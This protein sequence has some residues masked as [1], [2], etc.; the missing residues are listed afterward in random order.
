MHLQYPF[1]TV[2]PN[3][4]VWIP[5]ESDYRGQGT[6]ADNNNERRQLDGAGGEGLALC[7]S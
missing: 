4:G 1:T 5:P 7:V 6:S 3:L 2:I